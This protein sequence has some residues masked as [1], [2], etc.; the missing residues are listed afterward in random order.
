MKISQK[1]ILFIVSFINVI[2][3]NAQIQKLGIPEVTYFNRREYNG[4]TQN[5]A[6]TQSRSGLI[7]FANN[8]GVLE[9]DGVNW[10]IYKDQGDY[11]IRCVNAIN[12]KIY[13]ASYSEIGCLE[14]DS[15]GNLQYNSIYK[16]PK[17]EFLR[18]IWGIQKFN[19]K[20]IFQSERGIG[21]LSSDHLSCLVKAPSR[22][23]S[24]KVVNGM[25]L[26]QDEQTGLME[27]RG[28]KVYPI[29]GGTVLAGKEV[30]AMIPLSDTKIVIGTMNKGLFLYDMQKIVPWNVGGNE[31]LKKVNIFCG[32]RYDKNLMIFGTIQGGILMLDNEGNVYMQIDKD[33]G[34]KNNTVLSVFRDDEGNIWG[35]LDNGIVK[36]NFNS[37]ITFLQNYYDLGTGYAALKYKSDF[38]FGT[39]QGLYKIN[40][41]TLYDPLKT[42]KDFL[43]VKGSE[44]QV[45]S[46]YEDKDALLC[47]H[48]LG[49][50]EIK[51][52]IAY[53]ITPSSV[54]GV[55]NFKH[56]PNKP[57]LLIS[58][59]YNGLIVLE[60]DKN[61]WRYRNSIKNFKESS[62]FTEWD[63]DY[64]LWISHGYKGVF[65]LKFDED[66][67]EV[68]KVDTFKKSDFPG[69]NSSI[70]LTKIKGE[71][72][73]SSQ[74]GVYHFDS[75]NKIFI[76]DSSFNRYFV[77]GQFPVNIKEDR[78]NN[79]WCF[80]NEGV[81][82]LRFLEDGTYKRID[83]PFIPL[84]KKLVNSFES[85]YPFG[86][87][88]VFIGV[89]DGFAHYS[90]EEFKDYKT[91]FYVHIRSFSGVGDSV[92][93]Q[94]V[95]DNKSQGQKYIPVYEFQKNEFKIKYSA[96][97][98]KP[99]GVMYKAYLKNYDET[100]ATWNEET[101][102][103]YSN[104]PE[105][106][107]TFIVKAK[108]KYGYQSLPAEFKFRISPPWH[109]T[110]EAKV[111]FAV[112]FILLTISV[113]WIIN[114]RIELNKENE[115][116][117]QQEVFKQ[118]EAKLQTA[119]LISEKEVVK[120]RNEKLRSD[121]VFKE[122]ELANST[123]HLIQKNELLTEIKGELRKVSKVLDVVDQ[124]RKI[125]SIIRKIDKDIDNKNKWE[126][127]EMH[128]GQVHE[129]FF[130]RLKEL[131]PDLSSRE[132][133]LCAF[134]KM[135]MSSKEIA[136]L[137]NISPRAVENNR[138]KLRTKLGLLQGDNLL[139]Y[140]ENI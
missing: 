75:I 55:W 121:M 65:R 87:N 15:N 71:N 102:R 106:D 115:I 133:K 60:K 127:F 79:L 11:V 99:S 101:S 37:S 110:I 80:T 29:N 111:V 31:L 45:W 73:F 119:A 35:G 32:S 82:V 28:Q 13:V 39:N 91:S 14:Y 21:V 3:V 96:S 138:S 85:V 105:G 90:N 23:I 78:K 124:D 57:D 25:V 26:V 59:T 130:S 4:A 41:N 128:F 48:N 52:N 56:V 113:F 70:V 129:A 107:Y 112:L 61:K 123:I 117:R 66:F 72:V 134:I 77:N 94:V 109:R 135:G 8:D 10:S 140:I 43:R 6:I 89:E 114:R 83:Y 76:K 74:D 27:L 88:N 22:F 19:D 86:D 36:I 33:K 93:Y 9:F 46:L 58:G 44:G 68:I 24:C 104:L 18:E 17:L 122:K 116:I 2:T 120:M 50:Y 137:I 49:V 64:N 103:V 118:K 30:T 132:Q 34:L 53:L 95:K 20:V 98:Y 16:D 67:T 125:K 63:K 108:S 92:K 81:S 5:W 97:Y 139:K 42:N 100:D 69:N 84:R 62:R 7:Y 38:Y 136:A 126:L 40:E 131:H 1:R 54:N 12:D 51:E 47:G